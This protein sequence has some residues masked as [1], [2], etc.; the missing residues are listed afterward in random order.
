[1]EQVILLII[2]CV[3]VLTVASM[4]RIFTKAGKPGWASIIPIYNSVVQLEIVRKP[5]WWLLLML[6][7]YVGVVW[8][9]WTMNLLCKSF[10]K[11]S[12]FTIGVIFLPFIFL[13]ILAYGDSTY[14]G[15]DNPK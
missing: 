3:I 4:W 11:S 9:V 8:S 2:F 5:W 7:P 10:G 1:M 13:P 15:N 14:R 12:A 6:I